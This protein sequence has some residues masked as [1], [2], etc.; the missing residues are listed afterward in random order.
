MIE[1]IPGTVDSAFLYFHTGR[2]TGDELAPLLPELRQALPNTYLW[3]GD[4]PVEGRSDDPIIGR[5]TSYGTS[6]ERFW[7]VF[8][9]QSSTKAAFEYAAQAMGAVLLTCG[10]YVNRLVDRVMERFHLPASRVVLC[11]HQHGACAAWRQP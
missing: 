9:M 10:G 4:G 6:R 3:A 11:G 5:A 8:P 1:S 2:S 7:F